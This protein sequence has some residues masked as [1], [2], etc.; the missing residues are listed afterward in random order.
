MQLVTLRN[1]ITVKWVLAAQA[2]KK[3]GVG[4]YMENLLKHLNHLLA[5]AHPRLPNLLR[6]SHNLQVCTA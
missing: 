1:A 6:R 3:S 4:P 2:Q 5:S